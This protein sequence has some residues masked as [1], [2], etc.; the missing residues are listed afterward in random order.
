MKNIELLVDQIGKEAAHS[1]LVLAKSETEK[2]H[3]QLLFNILNKECDTA[4]K[5]AH[6]LIATS[7]LYATPGLINFYK[8]IKD[9]N[10]TLQN[11]EAFI[12]AFKQEIELSN[13]MLDEMIT[14]YSL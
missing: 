4:R 13:Q 11:N 1:L 12:N 3:E 10:D 5:I 9:G 6:D 7:N 8:T 14:K 2:Q